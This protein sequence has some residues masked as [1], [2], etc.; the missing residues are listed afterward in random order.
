[1]NRIAQLGFHGRPAAY[2]QRGSALAT[3]VTLMFAMS[4]ITLGLISLVNGAMS[5]SR[6]RVDTTQAINVAD[7]G[8]D[9]AMLWLSQQPAPPDSNGC[10]FSSSGFFGTNGTLTSPLGVS[11]ATLTVTINADTTNP[12]NT[13]KHYVVDSKATMASGTVQIVRAYVQQTSFGK[14]AMF[15]DNTPNGAYWGSG[16]N[17]FDGPVHSNNSNGG[18]P[19]TPTGPANNVLW[20]DGNGS[21]AKPIFTYQG[22]D[23]F[24]VSGPS[25]NWW[26]DAYNNVSGPNSEAEWRMIASGGSASVHT[27][28]PMVPLPTVTSEQQAA[29]LGGTAAPATV[30]VTVPHPG[31]GSAPPLGGVYIHGDVD[32]MALSITNSVNQVITI[33]QHNASNALIVTTV[34]QK[35]DVTPHQTLIST[36]TTP[37]GGSP[38]TT[39]AV[40]NGPTNGVIYCDGNIGS[41]GTPKT[42]GLSGTIADS[43]ALTIATDTSHN[44]NINGSLLL[45]TPR[46]KDSSGNLLPES[47][48]NNTNFRARAGTLG[49]V[50]DNVEVT[51]K[52]SVGNN[53]TNIEVDAAVLATGTY[54]ACDY[55][56]RPVGQMLNMGSYVVKTRGLFAVGNGFTTVAGIPCSRLYDNRLADHPPPFFPTTG[57]HY[58]LLSWQ[59]ITGS[60]L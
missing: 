33:T 53:I 9:L 20:S 24:T 7:S 27:G 44:T 2:R 6:K 59:R 16:L 42:G 23:A 18:S 48:P 55:R 15:M 28:T 10:K 14:Y 49:I 52:D 1:M 57:N 47:D 39:N 29:A 56:T 51:D 58:D 37:A 50:S 21:P 54:D 34:T 22:T 4:I 43:Q 26:R 36:T 40:Q 3:A 12:G 32:S 30:G 35:A 11:G 45:N 8:V 5:M 25:I 60:T 38:T 31:N 19:A 46:Q 13:Q 41:Q 17:V